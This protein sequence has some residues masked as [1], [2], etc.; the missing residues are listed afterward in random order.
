MTAEVLLLDDDPAILGMLEAILTGAGIRCRVARSP[1]DAL[2]Q[3]VSRPSIHAVVS[4][5]VMPGM[6]GLQFVDRL[7]ALALSRPTPRVLLLTAHPSL[8]AAV[9]A[10]RLGCRDFLVKPIRPTELIEAVGRVLT[11]ARQDHMTHAKRPEEVEHL[12]RQ[13]E[14]LAVR[15]RSIAY[16]SS[17]QSAES[18]EE[19]SMGPAAVS[20]V[21]AALADPVPGVTAQPVSLDV[22]QTIEHL[23]RLRN[24]YDEHGLDDVAWD[25]LL[26]LLRAERMRMRLSVSGLTISINNVSPTTS[27]RRV[28]ELS[29]RGYIA[30]VPDP[31]DARRDFVSLTTRSRELLADYLANANAQLRRLVP[32]Q[33]TEPQLKVANAGG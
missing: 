25:L 16:V 19:S 28:N 27:L 7:N 9:D 22:L 20:E 32:N 26:E 2:T 4:D 31:N 21:L 11:Q 18:I 10:L 8:E 24:V 13:A 30:R 23:R 15:L 1:A 12:M 5:L 33:T 3:I 29:N 17:P 14:L 6:N